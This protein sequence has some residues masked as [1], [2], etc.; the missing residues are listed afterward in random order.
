M[1][2]TDDEAKARIE[3]LYDDA[4]A[5]LAEQGLSPLQA[6]CLVLEQVTVRDEPTLRLLAETAAHDRWFREQVREGLEEAH[7]PN[8]K[9][10]SDDEARKSHARQRAELLARIGKGNE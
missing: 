10:I 6:Y 2:M 7:Y 4:A 5:V 1:I 8:T 3:V 9:W